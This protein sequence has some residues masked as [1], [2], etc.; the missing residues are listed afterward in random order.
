MNAISRIIFVGILFLSVY[1]FGLGC[2]RGRVLSTSQ[3]RFLIA[4]DA[5]DAIVGPWTRTYQI[6]FTSYSE[7]LIFTNDG[8]CKSGSFDHFSGRSAHSECTYSISETE[9]TMAHSSGQ[10]DTLK[11]TDTRQE[12]HLIS[13]GPRT[14]FFV[15]LSVYTRARP[16]T[17]NQYPW[18]QLFP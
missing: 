13:G 7:I 6:A 10:V 8:N 2:G 3:D 17:L 12:L 16:E 18:G 4:E 1:A 14:G 11:I 5:K 9:L 15:R